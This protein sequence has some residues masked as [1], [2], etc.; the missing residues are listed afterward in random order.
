MKKIEEKKREL[1]RRV[2]GKGEKSGR[3]RKKGEG[4]EG[5]RRGWNGTGVKGKEKMNCNR[6]M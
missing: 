3:V 2:L 6:R 1:H 4:R 5:K